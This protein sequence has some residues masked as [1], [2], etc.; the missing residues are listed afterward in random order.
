[1]RH[2][3]R[4]AAL[5]VM[6][7]IA[8]TSAG[9]AAGFGEKV[10][11]AFQAFQA[12]GDATVSPT[13]INISANIAL[14]LQ[15][16]AKIYLRLPRCNGSNG[17]ICRDPGATPEIGKAVLAMRKARIAATGFVRAHPG[18]LG[19]SGLYDGLQA[20]ISTV[21]DIFTHYDVINVT[22]MAARSDGTPAAP[23][24]IEFAASKPP[25]DLTLML[26]LQ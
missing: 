9:C 10:Q 18:Q 13:A 23:A 16:T 24:S 1:M 6:G 25:A 7:I 17:P 5:I 12:A 21:S 19:P 20:A 8:T 15:S 4:I 11:G 26:L 3:N 2:L 14:G 22:S